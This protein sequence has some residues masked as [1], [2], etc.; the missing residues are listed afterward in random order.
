MEFRKRPVIVDAVQFTKDNKDE[1]SKFFEGFDVH[2]VWLHSDESL[3]IETL[4]GP[5]TA[6][7]GDWI[8]RGLHDEF[9]PCKPEIFEETYEQV[10]FSAEDVEEGYKSL[11][12]DLHYQMV[13]LRRK[14]IWSTLDGVKAV[15]ELHK[16]TQLDPEWGEHC[17]HCDQDFP[18]AT[19]KAL[20]G[21][22]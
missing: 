12:E 6:R 2:Y 1:L 10:T 21:E 7:E 18:C 4:E 16:P 5:M 17:E 15:R 8:I 9:Y 20:E 22:S 11:A 19:I 13:Y 3:V 14:I